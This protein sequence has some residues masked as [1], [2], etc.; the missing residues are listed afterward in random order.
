MKFFALFLLTFF[1]TEMLR[2]Y[3]LKIDGIYYNIISTEAVEVTFEVFRNSTKEYNDEIIIPDT[4]IY[5][6]KIY[7]VE[8]IATYAFY[9]CDG[10]KSVKIP[11]SVKKIDNEAFYHCNN[12]LSLE[13]E[14]G[15]ET[16][17]L[18]RSSFVG[19]P[20]HNIYL[21]RNMSFSSSPFSKTKTLCSL[22]IGDNVTKIEDSAFEYCS[23]LTQVI[24]P[25]GLTTIGK[26]A[27]AHCQSLKTLDIPDTVTNIDDMAFYG[28]IGLILIVL[29]EGLTKINESTFYNCSSLTS[30][31]IPESVTEI[32]RYAFQFCSNLYSIILGK[33]VQSIGACSFYGCT[34]LTSVDIPKNVTEIGSGAFWGCCLLDTMI[35]PESI[36]IIANGVFSG[37]TNLTSVVLPENLMMISDMAFFGCCSLTSI[38]FPENVDEIG[39]FAFYGCNQLV[40]ICLLSKTPPKPISGNLFDNEIE[41]S[42]ILYVPKDCMADYLVHPYWGRFAHIIEEDKATHIDTQKILAKD[43]DKYIHSIQGQRIITNNMSTLPTGIYIVNGKKLFIR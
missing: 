24:L 4:I 17:L 2:A 22:T 21:D 43:T 6:E 1:C 26:N 38:T 33:N 10:L 11:G 28:C 30:L 41:Q 3:D 32:G 34:S 14:S 29:P 37:C 13:F 40:E 16:L 5:D 31:V 12:L 35:V 39:S 9:Y 36:R 18:D 7:R 23:N 19:C 42:A 20:I 25:N 15:F 8:K 27:F